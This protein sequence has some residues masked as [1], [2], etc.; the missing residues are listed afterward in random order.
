MSQSGSGT[1]TPAIGS[2]EATLNSL[3]DRIRDQLENASGFTEPL[4]VTASSIQLS[5]GTPNMRDRVEARLQDSGNTRWA[6]D[7]TDEAIRTALEHYSREQPH[8]VIGTI[9][10][11]A[12]GRE[13]DISALTG[14][15][16]VE[17]VWWDYD[18]TTPGYP[19]NWRQFEMWPGSILY[20]DDRSEPANGDTLR[21]WYTKMHTLNGLDS[22]SATTL[23]A[24]DA[25]IIVTGA[26]YF[27]ARARALELSESLNVDRDVVERL[28]EWSVTEGKAFRYLMRQKPPAWQRYAYAYGQSDIDEAI[29]WALHRYSEIDPDQTETDVTL[30]AAG[31][32]VDISSIT[33][34]L[35]I[36]RVWWDYDSASP[37][38]PPDW[39]D[40]ETW[41]GNILYIKD[42]SEP[43]SGDVVRVWYTR[44]RTIN[45]LDGAS[46][47]TIRAD[48]ETLLVIGA[49]GYAAQ[50]R[51]MESPGRGV[52]RKLAE[53]ASARRSEFER[54][55]KRISTRQGAKHSGIAPTAGLDRWDKDGSGWW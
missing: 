31:R 39:R 23:P 54:G 32:E 35:E 15:L 20:I 55:L 11:S 30:S 41:P 22:A 47:T 8:H 27:A 50:E 43:A 40:F 6:T 2:S 46:T 49:T 9:A 21:I 37:A 10:L 3:R 45:G 24:E 51:H 14:L 18:S 29:R 52:P 36:M 44:L 33:D 12:A 4:V 13:I 7:D 53:W 42:G 19:P 1:G 5:S 38:Y 48:L 17:K 28:T 26:S 16:R 34:Y 25:D